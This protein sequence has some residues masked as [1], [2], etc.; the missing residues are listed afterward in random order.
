MSIYNFTVR[1]EYV[2]VDQNTFPTEQFIFH[3]VGDLYGNTNHS[4][5]ITWWNHSAVVCVCCGR[6]GTWGCLSWRWVSLGCISLDHC[7][8]M[9]N[10]DLGIHCWA[11]QN[12][13]QSYDRLT[14]SFSLG[15]CLETLCWTSCCCWS[16]FPQTGHSCY[17]QGK[18]S[19]LPATVLVSGDGVWSAW[20][21]L[22]SSTTGYRVLLREINYC[23]IILNY[24]IL[25]KTYVLCYDNSVPKCRVKLICKILNCFGVGSQ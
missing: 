20:W 9:H 21:M 7:R 5:Y 1:S 13:G 2:V 22:T 15:T 12:P 3:P 4:R 16:I 14:S 6:K 10:S 19:R 25:R 11:V 8:S 17:W 23:M 18:C 24:F